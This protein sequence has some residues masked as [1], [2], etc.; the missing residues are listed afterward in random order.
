MF[1]LFV[2]NVNIII[3]MVEIERKRLLWIALEHKAMQR[4]KKKWNE[5]EAEWMSRNEKIELCKRK[6]LQQKGY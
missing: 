2:I 3:I 6:Y 5:L 4:A 1:C